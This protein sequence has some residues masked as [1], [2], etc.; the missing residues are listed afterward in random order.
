MLEHPS[1]LPVKVLSMNQFSFWPQACRCL[2]THWI[3]QLPTVVSA[4]HA[5]SHGWPQVLSS[6]TISFHSKVIIPIHLITQL[7]QTLVGVVAPLVCRWC[8]GV[9]YRPA[10]VPSQTSHTFL[11]YVQMQFFHA[12]EESKSEDSASPLFLSRLL[13]STLV[14]CDKAL[15]EIPSANSFL[16]T[17][18]LQLP[19]GYFTPFICYQ[20]KD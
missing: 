3:A 10:V 17:K 9:I 1:V 19:T 7:R 5:H 16:V 4:E 12:W 18:F 20:S 14:F 8:Q 13:V 15:F 6:A 11:V 2:T